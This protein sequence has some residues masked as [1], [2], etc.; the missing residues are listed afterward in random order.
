MKTNSTITM[1]NFNQYSTILTKKKFLQLP[2]ISSDP[3]TVN[4]SKKPLIK[5]LNLFRIDSYM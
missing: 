4:E 2:L 1:F 3:I 5:I